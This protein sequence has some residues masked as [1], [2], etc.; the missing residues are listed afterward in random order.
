MRRLLLV[1]MVLAAVVP[2]TAHAATPCRDRIYND[3][4]PDGKIK[5]TY[6]IAC[7]RDALKHIHSDALTYSSLADDI[8]S[9][10]Q[11]ALAREHGHKRVPAE[12]GKGGSPTRSST[13]VHP[14]RRG[15]SAPP[16]STD[17]GSSGPQ[18][19]SE[20]LPAS[21][22]AAG[23]TSGAGG[24]GGVPVP[25]IVLGG[26]ALLLAAAGVAGVLAKRARG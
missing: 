6:P 1:A 5:T 21:T 14:R 13:S 16:A 12:V 18:P 24:G 11:A 7:Y 9:A 22:V 26:F 10:M 15:H 19:V 20:T 2:A 23:P 25:L 4:Y 8:R 17:T 3:W